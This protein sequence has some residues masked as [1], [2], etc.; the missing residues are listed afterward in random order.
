MTRQL[1]KADQRTII[2]DGL[3]VGCHDLGVTA[4][5]ARKLELEPP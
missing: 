4:L 1:T 5:T 3:A 2:G